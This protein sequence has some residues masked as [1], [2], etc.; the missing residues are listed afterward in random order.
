MAVS[1]TL[2]VGILATIS[3][4]ALAGVRSRPG[5]NIWDDRGVLFARAIARPLNARRE[6]GPQRRLLDVGSR[7]RLEHAR[8]SIRTELTPNRL[9]W[10]HP[11]S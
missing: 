3:F 7:E 9:A 5:G 4:L 2:Q 8:E 11:L 10:K 1:S 6:S